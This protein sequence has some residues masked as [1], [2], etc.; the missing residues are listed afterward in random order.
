MLPFLSQNVPGLDAGSGVLKHWTYTIAQNYTE[1]KLRAYK[2]YSMKQYGPQTEAANRGQEMHDSLEKFIKGQ[3]EDLGIKIN[4]RALDIATRLR[5]GLA[6][7]ATIL[8]EDK[9][10]F[11]QDL[12]PCGY[13]DDS[14]MWLRVK[15]D[16]FELETQ[17]SAIC[18]DWKSGKKLGKEGIHRMQAQLYAV[19]GFLRYPELEHIRTQWEYIDQGKDNYMICDYTRDKAMMYLPRWVNLGREI[20]SAKTFDPQPNRG[21]CRFCPYNQPDCPEEERCPYGV[22][23]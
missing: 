8:V 21:N 7:G 1:C 9:W 5:E 13:Y 22:Q 6:N 18:Y 19:A 17:T 15:Q 23:E 4:P 12:N 20:T 11:D 14:K 10:A 2:K 3:Q 16:V